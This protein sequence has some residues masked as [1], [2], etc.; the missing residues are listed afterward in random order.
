[1]LFDVLRKINLIFIVQPPGTKVCIASAA[2]SP[3]R[4]FLL[5]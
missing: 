4:R 2:V 5:S 1:M 3:F